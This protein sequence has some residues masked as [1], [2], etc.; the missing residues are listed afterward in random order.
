[1]IAAKWFKRAQSNARIKK[2]TKCQQV[3]LQKSQKQL[4]AK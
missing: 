2:K 3:E 1:M 4:N